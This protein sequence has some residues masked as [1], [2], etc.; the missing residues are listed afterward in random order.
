MFPV[1]ITFT[2]FPPSDFVANDVLRHAAKLEKLFDRIVSL[3]VFISL[4]HRHR[5]LKIYH[6][7]LYLKSPANELV[8]NREPEK[9]Y[10]HSNIYVAIRDAF[11]ALS[12]QL[13]SLV[14]GLR[15]ASRFHGSVQQR[16]EKLLRRMAANERQQETVV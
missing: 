6:V 1:R 9:N 4:P 16:K 11:N 2:D 13:E 10:A 14:G 8:V 12:R 15:S 7:K 5:R 3:D